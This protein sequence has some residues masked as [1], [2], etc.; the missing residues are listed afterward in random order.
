MAEATSWWFN[1]HID[2]SYP[3][4]DAL[5]D[6]A[7]RL[8]HR[9]G[10]S[11]EAEQA[12]AQAVAAYRCRLETTSDARL[13][14]RLAKAL[15]RQSTIRAVLCQQPAD[16]L[17]VG[18]EGVDLGKEVLAAVAMTSPEFDT[19]V[20]EVGISLNDLSQ[21]AG[22]AGLLEERERILQEALAV[23]A[24]SAGPAA[25]QALGTSLH[26]LA[27]HRWEQLYQH[28]EKGNVPEGL[29]ESTVSFAERAVEIRRGLAPN[30]DAFL[31]WELANSLHLLGQVLC[32]TGQGHRGLLTLQEAR[33]PLTSI[34][35]ASVD[36]LVDKIAQTYSSMS[37]MVNAVEGKHPE[38]ARSSQPK[39]VSGFG[40]LRGV[41]HGTD[42]P[43][44][45]AAT[46]GALSEDARLLL[47]L[48]TQLVDNDRYDHVFER[49]WAMLSRELGRS[50][51]LAAFAACLSELTRAGLVAP[52]ERRAGDPVERYRIDAKAEAYLTKR[53]EDS[54]KHLIW[55]LVADAW[56][57]KFRKEAAA[58][59]PDTVVSGIAAS[60]YLQRLGRFAD[61]FDALEQA[62]K[63]ARQTCEDK[64]VVVHLR[65]VA[66]LSGDP[67][68][69]ARLDALQLDHQ[70]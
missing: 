38:P 67:R 11:D 55:K 35:G 20:R 41:E 26:N 30:E 32:M 34:R 57:S 24:L 14:R 68:L 47:E 53:M 62:L 50:A 37:E 22:A 40:G 3:K 70:R 51:S 36:Q 60:I 43:D 7:V 59:R 9:I 66:R 42:A 27:A 23:S 13:K 2:N 63:V 1:G 58:P 31:S 12:A 4:E 28:G 49:G 64:Y 52:L 29:I 19:I 17:V 21:A 46:I 25:R 56:W 6:E 39:L 5:Y 65:N 16:A 33:L 15:W 69:A 8:S 10:F 54:R 44:I 61:S 48:G 45:L 18:R